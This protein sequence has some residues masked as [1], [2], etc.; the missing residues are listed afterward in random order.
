MRKLFLVATIFLLLCSASVIAAV[1][2]APN[3]GWNKAIDFYKNKQ[4]DSAA[5]YF[6]KIAALKPINAAIYYNL[7]NTYYRENKIARAIL[8]YERAIALEPEY[9]EAKDN[10]A[11]AQTRI[12]NFIQPATDIFFV[13]W[14]KSVTHR[15]NATLWAV[16]ALT[17]FTVSIMLMAFR[18]FSKTIGQKVPVQLIGG[19]LVFCCF[20]LILGFTAARNFERNNT[21]IV[22]VN[23][24]ALM[25]SELRGKPITLTPEGTK[26]TIRS[27]KGIWIEVSL[28]DGRAGWLQ[29]SEVEKI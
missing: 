2:A 21:A 16:A 10:L 28:P 3:V 23:E 15:N 5:V 7:G 17:A 6:E 19:T 20:F 12:P 24:A 18:R 29:Q 25:T 1:P 14:W 27:Q 4:Y 22:M 8:N 9:K 13:K 26:V 11:V